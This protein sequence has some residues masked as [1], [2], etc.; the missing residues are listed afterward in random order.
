MS[1]FPGARVVRGGEGGREGRSG[2]GGKA[3]PQGRVLRLVPRVLPRALV[4]RLLVGGMFAGFGWLFAAFGMVFVLVFLPSLDLRSPSYDRQTHATITGIED[5]GSSENEHAIYRVSYTFVDEAGVERRGESFTQDAPAVPGWQ[6]G[7]RSADP[8]ESQLDG[9]RRRPF[10]PLLLFVLVFPIVGLGLALWQLPAAR[11]SL[12]LLHRGVETRGKLID[13]RAT[14]VEVNDTPVMALT[15]QYEV[16]GK[17]YS[18][19]VKT[20]RPE[21]LEDEERE[22][23]LYDPYSPANATTLDHLPG[24]PRVTEDGEI[25]ARPGIAFHFLIA[26]VAFVGLLVATVIR[27]L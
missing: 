6:V 22:A 18:T 25:E 2:S 3:A 8:S 24:G 12:R 13:K 7:Y 23:M 27:L 10:S 19:T 26:P 4:W 9:M 14:R 15:F 11:R 16:D 21:L 20:L 17:T 1:E 5:T